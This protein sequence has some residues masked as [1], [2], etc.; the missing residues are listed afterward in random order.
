MTSTNSVK[1][2]PAILC[3]DSGT[4]LWPLSRT[5][6]PKQF[7]YFT[8]NESLFQQAAQRLANLG[9]KQIAVTAPLIVSGDDHRFLAVEQQLR[10]VGITHGTVLRE[11]IGRNTSPPLTL[12]AL[13]ATQDWQDPALIVTPADQ[14]VAN[15]AAFTTAVQKA[16]WAAT[17]DTIVIQG[18]TPTQP[19][20]RYGHIQIGGSQAARDNAT[21]SLL[22]EAETIHQVPHFIVKPDAIT[23]KTYLEECNYFWSAGMF[24][25]KA[26]AWLKALEIF[27]PDIIKASKAAWAQ[28]IQDGTFVR[29]GKNEFTD[30]PA[31]SVAY[32]VI[33]RCLGS[34]FSIKMVSLVA[35]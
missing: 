17:D 25:L 27:R 32:A 20:I 28:S 2:Q 8:G 7:L 33:E 30:V 13:A 11:P 14:T 16:I 1:I 21:T 6:F 31:E 29:P 9:S 3:G 18:I 35:G 23:A 34:K 26:S 12:A 22:G 15:N 10:E 19:E 4:R 5:S 24:V